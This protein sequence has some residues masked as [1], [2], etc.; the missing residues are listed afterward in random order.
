[1]NKYIGIEF[2]D[3]EPSFKSANCYSLIE[4]FYKEELKIEIPKIRILALN[5]RHAFME[6]LK[7][8]S[9]NWIK[10]DKPELNCVV[11]M[12]HDMAHPK[13]VQH[14]GIYIGDRKVLHTLNKV[15]SHIATL[16]S[17]KPFIKG[18][19]KWQS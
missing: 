15:N 3:L 5:S 12:A 14:F 2:S 11:A 10:I 1:M 16:Q 4:L 6:Y 8:I 9:E 7:Q 13:I 17:L 19:Y 18:Y